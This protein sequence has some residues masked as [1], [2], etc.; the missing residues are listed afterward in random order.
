MLFGSD[1]AVNADGVGAVP[2][3]R[4]QVSAMEATQQQFALL[5]V[6]RLLGKTV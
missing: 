5:H 1:G 6:L 2:N 3:V 4:L